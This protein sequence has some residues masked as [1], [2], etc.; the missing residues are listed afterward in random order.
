MG[1]VLDEERVPP[2]R[3]SGGAGCSA[4]TRPDGAGDQPASEVRHHFARRWGRGAAGRTDYGQGCRVE[5]RRGPGYGRGRVSGQRQNLVRSVFVS[6]PADAVRLET[7][8][9][10]LESVA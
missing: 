9:V 4:H 6:R 10:Q 1:W 2:A 7:M 8:G 5:W 3:S